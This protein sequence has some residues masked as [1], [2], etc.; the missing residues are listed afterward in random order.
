MSFGVFLCVRDTAATPRT[1]QY[2][3]WWSSFRVFLFCSYE[4]K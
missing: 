3:A 1:V 4:S 2:L